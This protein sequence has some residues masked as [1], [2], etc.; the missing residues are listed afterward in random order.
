LKVDLSY[1]SV[2]FACD[3]SFSTSDFFRKAVV[4]SAAAS[5]FRHLRFG[6]YYS[7]QLFETSSIYRLVADYELPTRLSIG[8]LFSADSEQASLILSAQKT[9]GKTK[10]GVAYHVVPRSILSHMTFGFERE[11]TASKV[12][13]SVTS[14]GILTSMYQRQVDKS[15]NLSLVTSANLWGKAYTLGIRA[16]VQ[17]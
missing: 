16:T 10:V 4:E 6:A 11:F 17:Q 2:Y 15:R 3:G 14:G 1:R 5:G 12:A 13:A 9:V 7:R 8:C